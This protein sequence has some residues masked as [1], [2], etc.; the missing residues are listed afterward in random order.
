MNQLLALIGLLSCLL[1][2][3]NLP[4]ISDIPINGTYAIPLVNDKIKVQDLLNANDGIDVNIDSDGVITILYNSQV[5]DQTIN[6]LLPSILGFGEIPLL[7]TVSRFSLDL[8][9][10]LTVKKA[11]LKGKEI[12]FRYSSELAENINVKMRVPEFSKNGIPF[13]HSFDLK[14]EGTLPFTSFTELILLEGYEFQSTSNRLTF[15]YDARTEDGKR[16]KLSFAAMSFNELVFAYGEGSFERDIYPL[17]S[18]VLPINIFQAWKSGNLE[19]EDPKLEFTIDHSFG[20][21]ISVK[22]NK[23][24]FDLVDESSKSLTTTFLGNEIELSYPTLEEI[25]Q[26]TTTKILFNKNN[27]NINTLFNE[28]VEAVSYDLEAII[29]PTNNLNF[30]GFVTDESFFN[31]NVKVEL[32]LKQKIT[33]LQ[34]SDTIILDQPLKTEV[35]EAEFKIVLANSYPCAVDIKLTFLDENENEL[36]RFFDE[37]ELRIEGGNLLPEGNTTLS[38]EIVKFVS[39]DEKQIKDLKNIKKIIVEPLF[40][41]SYLSDGFLTL[42][43][44]QFLELRI[45]LIFKL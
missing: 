30:T 37:D 28:K 36:F 11:I 29:N 5:L 7:D 33:N 40:D 34:L 25:G 4:S 17:N 44:E 1:I 21:P 32:P 27:S 12:R 14:Y 16:V 13:E 2:S 26:T 8:G 18:E 31:L 39:L 9:T 3:C 35:T 19:F 38:E 45:G 22:I 23:V 6:D 15:I 10:N 43:D 24:D 41:S 20:F 42:Y